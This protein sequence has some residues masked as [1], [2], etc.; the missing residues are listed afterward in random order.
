MNASIRHRRTAAL[1]LA[2]AAALTALPAQ[3]RQTA[4]PAVAEPVAYGARDDV[5]ALA[6]ELAERHGLDPVWAADT[7]AQ[8][9][10][11]PSVVKLIQPPPAG[12][13]KNW[14]AYR[15]RFVEPRRIRAGVEFW[16]AHARWLEEAEARWGVPPAVVVGIVGVETIYGRHMGGF[17]VLDTLT[18]LAL[19]WPKDARRDRSALFRDELGAYLQLCRRDGLDPLAL[20]GSYAGASGMPQFLPSSIL[21]H[22]TDFDGDGRADLHAGA[23]DVIGSVAK[24]L[25]AYGWQ[26]GL[27]THHAVAEPVEVSDRATLLAPD[28]VPSFSAAQF[29]E[30]GAVLDDAGRRHEGLLALVELQ[31]GAAA[32]SYVAGT[33]NFYAIT[34]YNWSSYYAMAVI[35]LGEAVQAVVEA[36]R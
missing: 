15:A 34:R 7:L 30:R 20:R 19:D 33:A 27:A 13:A 3:A 2:L 4:R 9:R 10:H 16:R 17:R 22:A 1:I 28:I 5:L 12:T 26:R 11:L 24:Y 36:T 29:A 14:A 32:P 35:E 8:A 23:A 25:A 6:A 18:T 21:E 31:N